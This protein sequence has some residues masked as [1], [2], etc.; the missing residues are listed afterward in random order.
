[1]AAAREEGKSSG[2]AKHM[3]DDIGAKY[4]TIA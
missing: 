3:E 1:M 2:G 4:G